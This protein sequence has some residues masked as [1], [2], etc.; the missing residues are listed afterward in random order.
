M[1]IGVCETD[2]KTSFPRRDN[3]KSSEVLVIGLK[4]KKISGLKKKQKNILFILFCI[5]VRPI[6]NLIE[7]EEKNTIY[8]GYI[9]QKNNTTNTPL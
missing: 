9:L 8:M 5:Y 2:S 6:H 4:G 3:N 7:Q 1:F